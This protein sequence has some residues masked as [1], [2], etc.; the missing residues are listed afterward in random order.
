M[1]PCDRVP[2]PVVFSLS[3][4]DLLPRLPLSWKERI[5]HAGGASRTRKDGQFAF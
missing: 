2:S 4:P 1:A 3:L 5:F